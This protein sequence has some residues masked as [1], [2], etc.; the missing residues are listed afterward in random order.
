MYGAILEPYRSTTRSTPPRIEATT[1]P[2]DITFTPQLAL[3]MEIP[4]WQG[5]SGPL[6]KLANPGLRPSISPFDTGQKLPAHRPSA[7]DLLPAL[8]SSHCE[9]SNTHAN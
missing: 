2:Q 9:L 6:H 8:R 1:E 3:F 4:T 7:K 5:D